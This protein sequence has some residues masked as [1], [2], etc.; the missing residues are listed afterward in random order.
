MRV[1]APFSIL[2][3]LPIFRLLVT[4]KSPSPF[5]PGML[6][7]RTKVLLHCVGSL[8]CPDDHFT[9]APWLAIR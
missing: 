8:P 1:I 5:V 2:E 3:R 9:K 7:E 6:R 4:G